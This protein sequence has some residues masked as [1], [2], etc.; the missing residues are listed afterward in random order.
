MRQINGMHGEVSR[1][2]TVKYVHVC[3]LLFSCWLLE[4]DMPN[5]I[6]VFTRVIQKVKI[7]KQ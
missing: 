5:K 7:Q 6:Y 1:C 4:G 2:R 3:C